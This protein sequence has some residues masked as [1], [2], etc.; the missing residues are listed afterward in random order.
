[1]SMENSLRRPLSL[2]RSWMF[3]PGMD[4]NKQRAAIAAGADVVVADLEEFTL[5]GDRPEAR[6]RIVD[7]LQECRESAVV[8]AVRINKLDEDGRVDLAQIMPGKPHV[9][10]LPHVETPEHILALDM[11]I[12]RLE[13]LH[14]LAPG[15]TEI[16]P[17]IESAAGLL[18]LGSI[19]RASSRVNACLLA[20]E[21]LAANL[22]SERGVDG[23]ELQYARSRFLLECVAAG[24]V[25]IDCPFTFRASGALRLDLTVARR[26]GF[27][28]KCVVFPEHVA[29]VNRSFTP[30][31][32]DVQ[33]AHQLIAAYEAQSRADVDN[34]ESWIDAP[35]CNNARRLLA[36]HSEF[37]KF[38]DALR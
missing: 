11:E 5:M 9:V 15:A 1:M 37:L 14:G 20:A 4:E 6:R 16:V 33:E 32:L 25:A 34:I 17:T 21:D 27:K 3:V 38:N 30:S 7:L 26:L 22:G 31:D 18:S 10:F 36:R 24:C 13:T 23:I 12:S 2:R 8:G 29:V 35:C 28:A 19:L